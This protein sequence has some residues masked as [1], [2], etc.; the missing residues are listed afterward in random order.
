MFEW[1]HLLALIIPTGA[2]SILSKVYYPKAYYYTKPI[3]IMILLSPLFNLDLI[4]RLF[5]NVNFHT[6]LYTFI[7]SGLIFGLIGDILLLFPTLFLQGLIAFL[8]GHALYFV[9]F[10]LMVPWVMHP[11][12]LGGII[13]VLLAYVAVLTHSFRSKPKGRKFLV[14]ILV[15]SFIL[16][17]MLITAINF[18]LAAGRDYPYVA[19]GAFLFAISDS[20]LAW[21]MF[22]KEIPYA[23]GMILTTYYLAQMLI[24]WGTVFNLHHVK[25]DHHLVEAM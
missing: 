22:F 23:S 12:L 8:I 25:F 6:F 13:T 11:Y 15:Y 2:L 20:I 19:V 1:T 5:S 7:V 17:C 10:T 3:P 16:A 9:G 18:D 4:M 24:A 14:P 21:D